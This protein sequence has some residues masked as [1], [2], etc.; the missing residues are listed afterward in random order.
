M[1]ASLNSTCV[2]RHLAS[3]ESG[4]PNLSLREHPSILKRIGV[5]ALKGVGRSVEIVTGAVIGGVLGG[6]GGGSLGYAKTHTIADR[7]FPLIMA[8]ANSTNPLGVLSQEQ[9]K[10]LASTFA[11]IGFATIGGAAV[12][13]LTGALAVR[14]CR[15]QI[16]DLGQKIG[17]Q[18][19]SGIVWSLRK[20]HVV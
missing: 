7:L 17:S 8:T 6:L 10:E 20:I 5:G 16:A 2:H 15:V 9:V 14:R 12:G 11:T 4:D 19:A 18:A 3:I 13:A 1:R